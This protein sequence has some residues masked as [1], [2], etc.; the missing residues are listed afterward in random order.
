MT[1][2]VRKDA[3][4]NIWI[5]HYR[6]AQLHITGMRNVD[7]AAQLGMTAI[8]VS[9]ILGSPIIREITARMLDGDTTVLDVRSRLSNTAIMA[10]E[11]IDQLMTDSDVSP[12]V[13]GQLAIKALDRAGYS[14]VQKHVSMSSVLSEDDIDALC[15]RGMAEGFIVDTELD[16]EP[17]SE[18]QTIIRN[19]QQMSERLIRMSEAAQ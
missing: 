4:T 10:C 7:I 1:P 9:R 17:I 19:T 12:A 11:V 2:T 3:V 6:V 14:P 5:Q 15:N 13:R 18:K 16:S 8:N